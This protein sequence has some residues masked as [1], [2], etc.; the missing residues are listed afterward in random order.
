MRGGGREK[1]F[2]SKRRLGAGESTGTIRG[3]NLGASKTA[4]LNTG[5][6]QL[7]AFLVSRCLFASDDAWVWMTLTVCEAMLQEELYRVATLIVSEH[8]STSTSRAHQD[9]A[10]RFPKYVGHN[11]SEAVSNSARFYHTKIAH[12]KQTDKL[13]GNY[14]DNHAQTYGCARHKNFPAP[15][16]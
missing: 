4:K 5:G 11:I 1:R 9:L 10:P 3:Q 15:A 2:S 13:R 7:A 12:R 16:S 8:T 14:L 6:I